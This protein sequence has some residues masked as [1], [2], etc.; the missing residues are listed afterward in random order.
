MARAPHRI[1]RQVWRVRAPSQADAF[2]LRG[3]LRAAWED[4]LLPALEAAFDQA[5]GDDRVVR[6]PRLELRLRLGSAGALAEELPRL[7]REA[8]AVELSVLRRGGVPQ[9][10]E[11]D[12]A[13]GAT[14][15][16]DRRATL[17]HYLR[18]GALPWAAAGGFVDEV[19]EA[20][21]AAVR[22]EGGRWVDAVAAAPDPRAFAFR[23]LQLLDDGDAPAWV[24]ALAPRVPAVW[25]RVLLRLLAPAAADS[26]VSARDARQV[27]AAPPAPRHTRLAL[28]A[29]LL[30][31]ALARPVD[32]TPQA[33]TAAAARAPE[34]GPGGAIAVLLAS[35]PE[36]APARPAVRPERRSSGRR[37]AASRNPA[38]GSAEADAPESE[39][40]APA[41]S[42]ARGTAAADGP[43]VV[44]RMEAAREPAR[45]GEAE[46]EPFGVAVANAGL[47]LLHPFIAMLMER[48]GVRQG[49]AIPEH[50]LPRAAALLHYLATGSEDVQ[51]WELGLVKV[52]LGLAPDAPLLVAEG[53]LRP[54]DRE[55]CEGVLLSAITHWSVLK[56]SSPAVLRET[57]LRRGG[58][59]HRGGE[60]W[61]LRV[62]PAP[63]DVLLGQLPWGLS[64]VKLPW[65]P[66]PVYTEWTTTH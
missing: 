37:G 32:D 34:G 15:E 56:N 65:M 13:D 5:A 9:V 46:G 53:L 59:L 28:A 40:A 29:T 66:H 49:D 45:D 17:L 44:E 33:V 57:F 63:F 8:A 21:R 31:E 20:L 41:D 24:A 19:A 58:L 14:P 26:A 7:I 22:E 48:T 38:D 36:M 47:I 55:E 52:L 62:E 42:A 16:Q 64:L 6:I 51:E 27:D 61:L 11:A 4:S 30:A 25:R 18:T 43:G 10:W 23:L 1:R 50:A 35:L 60:G 12:D 39:G 54:E 2:A 3:E